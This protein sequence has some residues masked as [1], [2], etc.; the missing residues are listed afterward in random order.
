MY[1][2]TFC[3]SSRRKRGK[4]RK[5][6]LIQGVRKMRA[7][8]NKLCVTRL[9]TNIDERNPRS[10]EY[11]NDRFNERPIENDVRNSDETPSVRSAIKEN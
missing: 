4:R 5:R 11:D 7:E 3:D 8:M 9:R 2:R 1:T 6:E 10:Q